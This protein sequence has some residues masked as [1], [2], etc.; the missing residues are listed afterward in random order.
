MRVAKWLAGKTVCVWMQDFRNRAGSSWITPGVSM[1]SMA[2][3]SAFAGSP[4]PASSRPSP[5]P[6]NKGLRTAPLGSRS[7]RGHSG[8]CLATRVLFLLR[9]LGIGRSERYGPADRR[10]DEMRRYN[11]AKMTSHP[12]IGRK[13]HLSTP[14]AIKD[15]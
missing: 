15:T 8:L 13:R 12:V 2:E 5:A 4:L 6:A 11:P 10:Q 7:L 14:K 3:T 1:W 9:T